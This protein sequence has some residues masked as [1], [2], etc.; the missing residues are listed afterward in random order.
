MRPS[1]ATGASLFLLSDLP[2]LLIPTATE[3]LL[4]VAGHEILDLLLPVV[5]VGNA[6]TRH[7]GNVTVSVAGHVNEV[8]HKICIVYQTPGAT[9]VVRVPGVQENGP[10]LPRKGVIIFNQPLHQHQRGLVFRSPKLSA[11]R[12]PHCR[13]VLLIDGGDLFS[14][15]VLLFDESGGIPLGGGIHLFL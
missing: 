3:V 7:D 11:E 12:I 10:N 4:D 1:S 5:G 15:L 6:V 2:V 14:I 13:S 8:S 9:F